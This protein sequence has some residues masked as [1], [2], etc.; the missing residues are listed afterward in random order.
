MDGSS[1]KTK[2]VIYTRVSSP[3]QVENFSLDAQED[4]CKEFC[5]KHLKD[6]VPEDRIFREEGES[7]KTADRTQLKK[8]LKYCSKNRK[9]IR[10]VV[11]YKIDRFSRNMNDFLA[12]KM[13]LAKL[14]IKLLS[15]TE[16]IDADNNSS[17]L[18]ENI[19]ASFA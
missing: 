6:C 14:E 16:P 9:E 17:V 10:Y 13:V 15:A 18:M 1:K 5:L 12:L 19:I 4:I 8:M 11:V 3:R 2:A 7:A